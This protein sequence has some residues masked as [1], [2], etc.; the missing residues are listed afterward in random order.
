MTPDDRT[1]KSAIPWLLVW[2]RG[3]AAPLLAWW[4]I[5]DDRRLVLG[6]LMVAAFLSDWLDG[7]LARRWNTVTAALRRADSLADTVFYVNAL[8]VAVLGRWSVIQPLLPLFLGLA[9]LEIACQVTNFARFG[10]RTAT[11]AW[12]CKAWA[13]A[14]CFATTDLFLFHDVR[15]SMWISLALGYLAYIDVL[16]IVC[17]LPIPAVDVPS[18]L[19]AWRQ[20]AAILARRSE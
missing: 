4:A 6:G 12:L 10:C 11:H 19:H 13:V 15:A 1:W 9:G 16:A 5:L 2:F 3:G 17:I 7:V 20:R 18:S 14:L 8:G